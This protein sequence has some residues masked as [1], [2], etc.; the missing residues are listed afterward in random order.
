MSLLTHLTDLTGRVFAE[1]GLE[2]AHGVVV[3]SQ[4]P[5]LAQFQCNGA[6]TAA[7]ETG[8]PAAELAEAV[9]GR[10]R[11]HP[12]IVSATTAGPGFVNID[13]ADDALGLW[14]E[15]SRAD[16]HLGFDAATTPMTVVVDYAGPNVA[17]AM[18]VGHLRAT[19][20]GDSLARQFA[21][22]GHKVIRD[23]HFGDWGFQM[24]LLIAALAEE[25]PDL[26]FLRPDLETYPAES[27]VTL[28]D[29]QRIYPEAS[30]RARSDEE[31]AQRAREVTVVLQQGD[32][33]GY[34]ALWRHMKRVSEGSQRADFAAL[35]VNFDLWYGESD[36]HDRIDS[37]VERLKTQGVA[38]E[39][40]GALVVDVGLPDDKRE[41][42]PLILE[43]RTGGY[44]YST[45]DLATIDMRVSELGAELILYVVDRRQSD[46]FTQVFRAARKGGIAP[47]EVRLEHIEF[48]TMNGPDG[49]PFKTRAG[50]VVSL[51][52]VIRLITGAARSRLDEAHLAEEYPDPERQSIATQVGIAALKFGDLINNRSS[53]YVFDLDRFSSFEGKTGPYLQYAAVRI[54]SI[55]RLAAE[56][57]IPAGAIAAPMLEVERDLMLALLGFGEALQRSLDLRAPNHLADYAFGVAG[58][59]NRFYDECHILSEEDP[60]RRGSWMA[61][62]VWTLGTLE[63]ALQLL[64]IEVPE[65]M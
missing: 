54:K 32:H 14:S 36:V 21:F 2:P 18:H 57:Q 22:A 44:L 46:H 20:I 42:P 9:A 48:G 30:E 65:R 62:A 11:E 49:K 10:L 59:F 15:R 1:L 37:M 8:R 38:V 39:S 52:D 25:R 35:G 33:P 27:P 7:R 23:P 3:R 43:S 28:E 40:E 50:G 55:L 13:V 58:E 60:T 24:G 47:P 34:R 56:R 41:W 64:G 53:D 4:R 51:G 12:E 63:R 16:P 45:T 26:P 61:L 6:M 29:L 31:F 19:I 17:K 5:D